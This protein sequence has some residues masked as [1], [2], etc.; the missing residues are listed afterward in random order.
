MEEL[1]GN[2]VQIVSRR[3]DPLGEE[4]IAVF[5]ISDKENGVASLFYVDQSEY[6]V[7]I[8]SSS[9][10]NIKD[11]RDDYRR[12]RGTDEILDKQHR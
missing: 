1:L 10:Q 7:Q 6:L 3:G 9:L 2:S 5:P 11:F 12:D 8:T 4:V